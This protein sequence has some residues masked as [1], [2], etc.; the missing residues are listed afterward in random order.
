VILA[1]E[2]IDR[3]ELES[4]DNRAATVGRVLLVAVLIIGVVALVAV[5]SGGGMYK[6]LNI[7]GGGG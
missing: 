1:W 4:G 3:V 7:A 5:S 2:D 6:G